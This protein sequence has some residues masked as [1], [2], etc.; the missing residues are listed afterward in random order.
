MV[1]ASRPCGDS[2]LGIPAG[3]SLAGAPLDE[4]QASVLAL[5]FGARVMVAP[6]NALRKRLECEFGQESPLLHSPF[7]HA[8]Q[9]GA[10]GCALAT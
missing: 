6:A 5:A 3:T 7:S 4:R 9:G 2:S 8:M 1:R 10:M